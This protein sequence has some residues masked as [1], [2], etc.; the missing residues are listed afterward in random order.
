LLA[1]GSFFIKKE[2]ARREQAEWDID[3]KHP[4]PTALVQ[5]FELVGVPLCSD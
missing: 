2:A 5:I 1:A 3:V 4:P